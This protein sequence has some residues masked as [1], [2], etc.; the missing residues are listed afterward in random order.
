MWGFTHAC[1][2]HF[3]TWWISYEVPHTS[4]SHSAWWHELGFLEKGT[5]YTQIFISELFE[6]SQPMMWIWV[7]NKSCFLRIY[8]S[9]EFWEINYDL[10]FFKCYVINL[11]TYETSLKYHT[12]S[13]HLWNCLSQHKWVYLLYLALRY[14]LLHWE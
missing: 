8:N 1:N 7:G 5:D 6:I 2:C 12:C 14:D 3:L 11:Q 9:Y 10:F 4:P 13:T